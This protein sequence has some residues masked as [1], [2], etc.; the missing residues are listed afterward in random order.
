MEEKPIEKPREKPFYKSKPP[1]TNN[2]DLESSARVISEK[3]VSVGVAIVLYIVLRIALIFLKYV[4]GG[5]SKLPIIK[6]LDK[7]GGVAY[8]VLRGAI[9]I[10][11]IL[12][13]LFFVVSLNDSGIISEAITNSIISKI[14]YENNIILEMIF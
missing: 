10:Y 7:V 12:A 14:L 8:G 6:Q 2:K 1:K 11:I 4:V 13:I 5:I 3:I 9:I